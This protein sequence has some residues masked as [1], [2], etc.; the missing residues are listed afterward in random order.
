MKTHPRLLVAFAILVFNACAA[1]AQPASQPASVETILPRLRTRLESWKSGA[2]FPGMTA[3]FVLPDGRSGAASIGLADVENKIALKPT[4]RLLSG[5]TGKTFVAAVAFQLV[6]ERTLDL[7]TKLEKWL[8]D[9]PWFD[10]LPNGPQITLRMLLNHTSG[11]REHVLDKGLLKE[12]REKPDRVWKPAELL[13]PILDTKPLFE[14]GHGWSYADTNYIL[15][16]MVIEKATKRTVYDLVRQRLLGPLKLERT[17][18]ADRRDLPELAVGYSRPD[19]PFGFFGRTVIDGK[20][21]MNPQF[22]WCGGGFA[23]TAE[24]LARWI[25]AFHEGQAFDPALLPQVHDGK[26]ANTGPGDKYG[27][28][29]QIRTCPLGEHVGHGGWF[30]GYLTETI[31]FPK[32]RIAVAV[33]FNTDSIARLKRLPRA[34]AEELASLVLEP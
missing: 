21:V 18:P 17:I 9:E 3:A 31:Y 4:D 27:L 25:K 26:A 8:G 30:P 16:G 19:S 2:D 28:A 34:Y 32:Q 1:L 23:S 15:V 6:T 29:C 24:D 33:Q 13:E 12:V 7:D 22:E 14:A 20:F 10:R 5:S 11:I